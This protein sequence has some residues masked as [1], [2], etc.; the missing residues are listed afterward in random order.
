[1]YIRALISAPI[2]LVVL[3]PISLKRDMSSLAF[4]G[5]MSILSLTYTLIVIIVEAPFYHKEYKDKPDIYVK[6]FIMDW[7]I[8][9]SCSLVFF[10]FTCQMNILPIYSELVRPDERRINKV[11][12]RAIFIDLIFYMLIAGFGYYST[13]NY[14]NDNVIKRAPLP[15][16]DPDY[17]VII[18]AIAICLVLFAAFPMNLSPCRNQ[19]F[20]LTQKTA[21]YSNKA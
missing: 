1:M 7:N 20:L 9:T 19:F 4:A 8:F 2:A 18:S 14:T 6:P 10:A 13:L 17:T 12:R 21:N 3:F 5:L 11:V 16:Y 15:V